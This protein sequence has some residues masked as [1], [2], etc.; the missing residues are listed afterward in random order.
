MNNKHQL[1]E[2]GFEKLQLELE[3][4]KNIERPKVIEL[5]KEARGQG[6]LSEN[7]DY[8]VARDEQAKLE[9]RIS[10]LEFILKN[11]S[12]IDKNNMD[13][14]NL[15]K[16]ITIKFIGENA[17]KNMKLT[18][19]LVSS[20]IETS[21]NPEALKL[22]VDSPIGAACINSR[23]GDKITIKSSTGKEQEFQIVS[24][25]NEGDK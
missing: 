14:E 2:K 10:E 13:I 16:I 23:V 21:T 19:T 1:T 12:I 17:P 7:A 11:A 8:D 25:E 20:N 9:S 18:F 24:L 15:G 22:S 3:E 5:I 6:D 4:L